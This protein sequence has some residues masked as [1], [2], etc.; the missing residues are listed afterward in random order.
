MRGRTVGR[1]L[2]ATGL[3][4]VLAGCASE[5]V[6]GEAFPDWEVVDSRAAERFDAQLVLLDSAIEGSSPF[7]TDS[8][9]DVTGVS[10]VHATYGDKDTGSQS[11]VAIRGN[12]ASVF[13]QQT[14]A[15]EGYTIDTL[16]VGGESVDY[17]LLGDGYAPL[18]PTPWVEVP[19]VYGYPGEDDLVSGL[20]TMCFVDGFQTVCEVREAIARTAESEQGDAMR[21][22]VRTED[23][24]SVLSETEVTLAAVLEDGMILNLPPEISDE[25]S[26]EM[27][28]SFVPVSLWQDA[29]GQLLKMELN[30]TVRGTDGAE[31]LVIQVGFEIT[32]KATRTDFPAAPAP[33][34]VTVVPD[35]EVDAFY[36][37]MGNLT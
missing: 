26:D 13:I 4:L 27:L 3:V 1:G 24:G 10:Y 20:R 16:H 30:G 22:F 33:A 7:R 5:P 28:E 14:D 12:P 17:L 34:D 6:D 36:T 8:S 9:T 31:D 21:R 18:A 35:A 19:T 2:L 15:D 11:V 29:D 23:D 32:G 37:E 25:L